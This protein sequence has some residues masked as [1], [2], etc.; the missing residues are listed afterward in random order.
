MHVLQIVI[1]DTFFSANCGS[2]QISFDAAGCYGST[3]ILAI[4]LEIAD[5]D[6]AVASFSFVV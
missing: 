1:L 2:R 6:K 4:F 5:L 3:F